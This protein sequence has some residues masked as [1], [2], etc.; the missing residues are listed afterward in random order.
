[1]IE[2][3]FN[4]FGEIGYIADNLS[5]LASIIMRIAKQLPQEEYGRQRDNLRRAALE[6]EPSICAKRLLS[7][8]RE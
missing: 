5:E 8:N 1:M 3:K 6:I 7:L 4:R 2:A